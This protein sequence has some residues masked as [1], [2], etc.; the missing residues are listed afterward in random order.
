MRRALHQEVVVLELLIG[1]LLPE[2]RIILA[3]PVLTLGC[4]S[5]PTWLTVIRTNRVRI[6]YTPVGNEAERIRSSE[7]RRFEHLASDA[8][9]GPWGE[10]LGKGDCGRLGGKISK[11]EDSL[12]ALTLS[13]IADDV[14]RIEGRA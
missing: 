9:G 12:G 1:R 11:L 4:G 7:L 5:C 13:L 10:G 14:R 6:L 8:S 2:V 3:F